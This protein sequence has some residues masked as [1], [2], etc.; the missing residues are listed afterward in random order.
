MKYG[1]RKF[2]VA[3]ALIVVSAALS[4]YGRLDS[5]GLTVIYALVGAGYG[6]TNVASK[7]K[8]KEGA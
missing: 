1:S 5:N 2:I 7:P 4:A 8:G 6:L 3:M